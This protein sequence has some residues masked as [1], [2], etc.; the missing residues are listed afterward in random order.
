MSDSRRLLFEK[1]VEDA[2][3]LPKLPYCR[4]EELDEALPATPCDPP[5]VL[6]LRAGMGIALLLDA[7]E[8]ADMMQTCR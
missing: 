8:A 5:C 3:E 1:G 4:L 7:G 2:T 6:F